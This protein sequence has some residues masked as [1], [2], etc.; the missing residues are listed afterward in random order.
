MELKECLVSHLRR[1]L[2]AIQHDDLHQGPLKVLIRYIIST[3]IYGNFL[4]ICK[5][6]YLN[7]YHY[8]NI[9]ILT[10]IVHRLCV[11]LLVCVSQKCYACDMNKFSEM[12]EGMDTNVF[13]T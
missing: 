11:C 2:P 4:F 13:F 6:Y 8:N 1:L 5:Y 3:M 9:S 12:Y 10:K 7:N